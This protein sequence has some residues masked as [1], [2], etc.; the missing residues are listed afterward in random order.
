MVPDGNGN[1]LHGKMFLQ[2][3]TERRVIIGLWPPMPIVGSPAMSAWWGFL[4][5]Q[6]TRLTRRKQLSPENRR[7]GGQSG[8][9]D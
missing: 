1:I 8:L 6:G 5:R 3:M 9:G 4:R 2:R 7:Y